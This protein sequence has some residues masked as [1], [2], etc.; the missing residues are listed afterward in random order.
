MLQQITRSILRK[1]KG[2]KVQLLQA[3]IESSPEDFIKKS[4]INAI[5]FGL[6]LFFLFL[7]LTALFFG[8]N[9]LTI[10]VLSILFTS[11]VFLFKYFLQGP[12]IKMRM[13]QKK[14]DADV[15]FVGR[16]LLIEL[17]S[18]V[19][20]YNAIANATEGFGEISKEFQGLIKRVSLGNPI[21]SALEEVIRTTPSPYFRK[22]LWQILN[23]LGTGAD[24]AQSLHVILS[25]I[26]AEQVVDMREYGRKLNP[27]VMFYLMLTVVVPSLGV[28]VLT[29]LSMF[30]AQFGLG[31][32]ILIITGFV[33][34]F[35]QFFFLVYIKSARP[36]VNV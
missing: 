26:T 34:G 17:S 24:I 30:M 21:D 16:F 23:A 13:K 7:I 6:L 1:R 19:P 25:Q 8:F 27:I 20:L 18:G 5:V 10:I 4:L 36:G 31:V 29:I 15:L 32:N 14:I 9:I 12:I 11:P 2:F 22:L 33:V 3:G 35:A 28:V